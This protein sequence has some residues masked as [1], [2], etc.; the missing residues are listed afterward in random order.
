MYIYVNENKKYQKLFNK[1]ALS[2]NYKYLTYAS[3]AIYFFAC[4]YIYTYI[5]TRNVAVW[6]IMV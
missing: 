5:Y 4:T 6:N 3:Y 2:T 1:L